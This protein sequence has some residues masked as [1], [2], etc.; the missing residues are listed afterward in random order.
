MTTLCD[1]FLLGQDV[2]SGDGGERWKTASEA[3]QRKAVERIGE[4]LPGLSPRLADVDAGLREMLDVSLQDVFVSAWSTWRELREY[5]DETRHP[6]EEQCTWTAKTITFSSEHHPKLELSFDGTPLTA[7]EFDVELALDIEDCELGIRGGRIH[8]MR[9]G[10]AVP[11]GSLKLGDTE[12]L[13]CQAHPIALPG[14]LTFEGG[15]PIPR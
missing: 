7:V 4:K 3:V 13:S 12:L 1:L 6:R 14:R 2:T 10:K 15:I 5:A 11:H 9:L 8:E